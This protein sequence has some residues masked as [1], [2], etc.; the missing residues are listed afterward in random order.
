[1]APKLA[2]AFGLDLTEADD[3][4]TRLNKGIWPKDEAIIDKYF[5]I[6]NQEVL[7]K[8]NILYVI[9]WLDKEQLFKFIKNDFKIVELHANIDELIKRKKQGDKL[10]ESELRRFRK[11]YKG[12]I[13]TVT[14]REVKDKLW[15]SLDTTNLTPED[16]LE[17]VTKSLS[18]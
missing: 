16:T 4:V 15:I 3:E 10:T 8:E 14:D 18:D 6:T 1:M 12:Y 2:N 7:N 17:L 13:E 11:N 5:E 9:S